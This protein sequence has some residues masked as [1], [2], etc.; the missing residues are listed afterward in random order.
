MDRRE[1]LKAAGGSAVGAAALFGVY[2]TI[3]RSGT[4]P[5]DDA[6][7]TDHEPEEYDIDSRPGHLLSGIT[8]PSRD[9][10]VLDPREAWLGI[11]HAVVGIFL[12]M[13]HPPEEVERLTYSVIDA[14]WERGHV[15]HIF[16]QPFLPDREETS[17][18]INSE[19]AA[20]EHDDTIEAWAGALANW[21]MREDDPDRR[22]Y[23]N[24]APEFNGDWSPWSPALGNDDEEDF[25]AMWQR[26]HDTVHETGL[27]SSHVQWIWTLDNATRG[28]DREACYPGDDYIDWAGVHGY[29]W[30]AW[31]SW[32]TPQEVYGSTISTI[33]NITDAPIAITEFATSSETEEGG[34][35]PGRKDT[36]IT[37]AY[38]FLRDERVSMTLYFD[39]VKE[40]DWAIF[41]TPHGTDT[42]DIDGNEYT[43]SAAYRDA[44]TSNGILP[45][46]PEH[47]RL[48]TDDEFAGN[49]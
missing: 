18:Q 42:V 29:N 28:V 40:T 5:F 25:V 2:T 12:D 27:D 10:T 49:L 39:F 7:N 3:F 8:P 6:I 34:N 31:G 9:M 35:D 43:V 33:Y 1:Y 38:A 45:A 15:P 44:M 37:D 19:I 41:D 36:W 30:S 26:I 32:L 16:W 23:L 48:L 11:E 22:L 17:L 13:G 21:A 24:L 20:G 14:V 4:R 46:H 47:P